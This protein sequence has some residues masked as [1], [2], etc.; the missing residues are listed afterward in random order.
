M[1]P[2][3][4]Q[5]EMTDQ[6]RAY[7]YAFTTVCLWSTVASACK[8]SLRYLQPVELLFY[9]T[10][11]SCWVLFSVILLQGKGVMLRQLGRQDWLI[12][13]KLGLL[14]PFF[15]YLV[16]FKAYDLL[17]AQQAQPLN[18]TWAITLTLLSIP[19]LGQSIGRLQ[20]LAICVSYLGVLIISTHG[21]IFSLD[22]DSPLGVALALFSTV[23]WALY[24]IFNTM[25]HRDPVIGLFL[26]FCCA[27]PFIGAYMLLTQ[28]LRVVAVE[29]LLGAAYLGVFEMGIAYVFWL[30]AM[31]LS[32]D[33]A[34]IANLIFISPFL[35]LFFIH[36]LVGETILPAT[37][38]GLVFI[39]VGLVLQSRANRAGKVRG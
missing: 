13:L 18:Y 4:R 27:L 21:D 34:K 20:V 14:N 10:I 39:I 33:T 29:G 23:L 12:S 26:N 2:L 30:K 1:G 17:P 22:F 7:L 25:D 36:F 16:L 15:Y 9:A 8:L 28:G 3:R 5:A 37:F 31:K 19:L 35:S 11:V 32:S 24:W 6:R 38:I